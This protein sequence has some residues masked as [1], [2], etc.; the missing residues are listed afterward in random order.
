MSLYEHVRHPWRD[1]RPGPVRV[2]DQHPTGSRAAR[3]NA[4][5][6]TILTRAVGTM[7]CFYLFNLLASASAKSAFTSGSPTVIVN[8][9]SSNWIQLILLPALM[10]GQN[11][12]GRAADARSESTWKDAEAILHSADQI[13]AHLTAQD[14]HLLEQDGQLADLV[15]QVADLVTHLAPPADGP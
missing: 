1:E 6:A 14:A 3:F 9:A 8:W 5:F 7:Y 11:L 2:A 10:V 13:A 15:A 4:R 12:Q